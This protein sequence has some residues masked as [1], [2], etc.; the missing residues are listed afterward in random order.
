VTGIVTA[1]AGWIAALLALSLARADAAR[2]AA[3]QQFLFMGSGELP[4]TQNLLARPDIAGV[5]VVYSW[6]QLEPKEDV[7]DLS[8]IERDLA[9]AQKHGKKLFVQIQDRFFL[10]TARNVPDYLLND[11]E[12]GGGLARQWDNPGEGKAVASGW[13]ARQWD[14][15][16]RRRFQKLLSELAQRFDGRVYGINLPE[17]AAD[18][19]NAKPEGFT[20]D[21]YFA[22]EIENIGFARRA[23][24]KSHVVQYVNFWPCEW[25]ND[26]NYM[27]RLFA[28]AQARGIGLGGP[29]IVPF[30]R[31]QMKNAYPFFNRYRGKLPI[32]AMVRRSISA[33]T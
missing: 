28:F 17:T 32:V 1:A 26:R 19:A 20:C 6:R 14:P 2:A 18:L 27:G 33:R 24:A 16:L 3:P 8:A 12:Y 15:D 31:G 10:P 29:D 7:Y 25:N 5:Q 11:P 9:I 13:I 22:A 4:R 21:G 30:R 23:F